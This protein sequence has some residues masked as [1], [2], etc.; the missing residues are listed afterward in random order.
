[1]TRE[2]REEY[3]IGQGG[4]IAEL[5]HMSFRDIGTITKKV[6][7]QLTAV[8]Y[9]L[10][11]ASLWMVGNPLGDIGDGIYNWWFRRTVPIKAIGLLK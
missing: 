11:V 10:S 3:V 8:Y 4:Q 9:C 5:P 1:M 7:L 6:K 2:E